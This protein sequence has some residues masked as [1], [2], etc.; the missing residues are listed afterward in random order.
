MYVMGLQSE[1]AVLFV[2]QYSVESVEQLLNPI[3]RH[4]HIE[5]QCKKDVYSINKSCVRL[6]HHRP[7]QVPYQ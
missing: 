5:F 3:S 4:G 1:I 2:R 7:E 6:H